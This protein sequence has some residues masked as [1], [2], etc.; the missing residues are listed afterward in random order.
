MPIPTGFWAA[1]LGYALGS[2]Q[3]LAIDWWRSR[4]QHRRQLRLLRAELR[5]L[6]GFTK[7]FG[8][9]RGRLPPN[10]TLP[11]PPRVTPGYLRLVQEID[12]WLTDEH[13]DD[14]TQ[15]GLLDITDGCAILERYVQDVLKHVDRAGAA[16]SGEEKAKWR[17]RAVET[18]LEYDKEQ[19]RWLIIVSSAVGDVDRRIKLATTFRQLLR[20]ARRMPRGTNP[21]SLPPASPGTE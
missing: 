10:D 1:L 14:N 21:P 13:S 8:W 12:F 5:R 16:T 7:K 20:G 6:A 15:Q 2:A 4:A 17:E 19:S 11:N 18:A 3:V 9:L